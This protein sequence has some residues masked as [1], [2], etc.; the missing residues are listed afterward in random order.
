M[1]G[2]A[3]F[4]VDTAYLQRFFDVDDGTEAR[5]LKAPATAPPR[6]RRCVDA[7]RCSVDGFK[8]KITKR[9]VCT[10]SLLQFIN[11]EESEGGLS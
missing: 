11:V 5:R 1:K 3:P 6:P 9:R 2:A 8:V 10:A 7:L 4:A